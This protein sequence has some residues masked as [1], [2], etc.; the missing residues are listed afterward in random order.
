MILE[1]TTLPVR[2]RNGG[3]D[4]LR[5][6]AMFMVVLLHVLGPGGILFELK[7]GS[8]HFAAAWLLEMAIFCAI[9]C[10]GIISGYVGVESRYKY[11]NL[12][13]LWLQVAGYS[14]AIT[15]FYH[16][17]YPTVIPFSSVKEAFAPVSNGYYWYVTAYVGMFLLMPLLNAAA[18]SLKKNQLKA[19]LIGLFIAL[20]VL[21]SC[22]NED[23]FLTGWG[24]STLWLSFLY[25]TGAYIKKHGFFK[26]SIKVALGLY[27]ICVLISWGV[28]MWEEYIAPSAYWADLAGGLLT[29]YSSPTMY[30]SGVALFVIFAN[31]KVPKKLNKI[32]AFIAPC[33]FGVYIIHAHPLMWDRLITYKYAHYIDYNVFAMLGAAILTAIC[34]FALLWAVDF[35]RLQIFKLLRLKPLLMK[36]EEKLIGDLWS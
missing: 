14:V 10:Y 31:I 27:T 1:K 18:N 30:L 25:V 7:S 5:I 6:F 33:T 36:A 9:N 8:V 16:L 29:Q 32:I 4:L 20:C 2:E 24:Y 35:V 34:I 15:L 28:K 23:I 26:N 3:I 13:V 22:F 21:P 17:R 19:V 12:L 11:S